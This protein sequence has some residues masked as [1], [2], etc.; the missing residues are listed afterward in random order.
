L[1]VLNIA[2]I[3]NTKKIYNPPQIRN[4]QIEHDASTTTARATST[5]TT[6]STTSTT[7]A[8]TS[9]LLGLISKA[10]K[11]TQSEQKS[12]KSIT[13]IEM[14]YMAAESTTLANDIFILEPDDYSDIISQ[15]I[16]SNSSDYYYG[17]RNSISYYE[18][19]TP[20]SAASALESYRLLLRLTLINLM[21]LSTYL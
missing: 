5:S 9:T 10:L 18:K 15:F 3:K 2:S 16:S 6:T 12:P 11:I 8:A 1:N 4:Y 13:Y 19:L 14:P 21:F 17:D 20:S 7:S